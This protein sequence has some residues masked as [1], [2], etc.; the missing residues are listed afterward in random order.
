VPS[1]NPVEVAVGGVPVPDEVGAGSATGVV[2][3]EDADADG[4]GADADGEEAGA[5]DLGCVVPP[6]CAAPD[7]PC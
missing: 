3:P 7:D 1:K 5:V 6:L 2:P 4:E